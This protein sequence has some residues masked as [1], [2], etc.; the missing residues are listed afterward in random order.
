MIRIVSVDDL[1]YNHQSF[2]SLGGGAFGLSVA[3]QRKGAEHVET[4]DAKSG[5]EAYGR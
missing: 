2:G 1:W 4:R 5:E 3:R